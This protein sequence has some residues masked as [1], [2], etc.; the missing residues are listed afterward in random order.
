MAQIA[1]VPNVCYVEHDMQV[2]VY[3]ALQG[4]TLD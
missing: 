4:Y 2:T 3:E 1:A